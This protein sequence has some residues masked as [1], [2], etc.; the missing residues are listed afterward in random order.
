MELRLRFFLRKFDDLHLVQLLLS[1]H[2]H[3]S[4]RNTGLVSRNEIL[5]LRDLRLLAVVSC[6]QLALFHLVDFHEPVIVTHI[7]VK[8]LVLHM[9]DQVY[10][11]V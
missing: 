7:A 2:C 1:R 10:H 9:V 3:V 8:L 4:R 11:A 5:K 6:L